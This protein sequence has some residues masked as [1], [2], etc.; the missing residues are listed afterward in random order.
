VTRLIALLA[1][2]SVGGS[3]ARAEPPR[4]PDPLVVNNCLACHAEALL[5]QQRLTLKQWAAVV[6]KMQGW[7]A[8]IE[9][10]H[11]DALVTHLATRYASTARYQPAVVDAR[12]AAAA[13]APLPDGPFK[14][15][16]AKKGQAAYGVACAGCHGAD[17][18]GSA[19]GVN[20]SDRPLLWRAAEFAAITRAGRGRMPAFTTLSDAD[21]AGILVYLRTLRD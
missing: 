6:K 18:H 10:E 8:P 3:P 12:R 2:L 20:L 19:T 15:G 9:P 13:L 4:A 14:A 1:L 16:D 7:G 5:L 17:G 21:L 11:V